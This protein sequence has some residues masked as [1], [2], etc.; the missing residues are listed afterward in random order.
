MD[1]KTFIPGILGAL[2]RKSFKEENGRKVLTAEEKT[3]LQNYGFSDRFL[4]DL[5]QYLNKAAEPAAAEPDSKQM[6][7]VTALLGQTTAQL[8]AATAELE[9][10]RASSKTSAEAL[11]SKEAAIADLQSKVKTLSDMAEEDPGAAAGRPAPVAGTCNLRDEN[12][13][14]GRQG[15]MFALADRPYNMRAKAALL[16]REGYSMYVAAQAPTD[17]TRLRDDLG[18]FYRIPWKDRLQSLLAELPTVESIFPLESGFQ[19]MATLVNVWLGEFSQSDNTE[20]SNFDDVTKGA[21]DFGSE[22]LRMF[23]VMFAV[24][25]TNLSELERLW[26]GSLNREGSNPIKWSFVEFLLAE[27]SKKLHNE[28]EMRRINGVRKNPKTNE[29][30]RAMDA[31]D[32]YF[33]FIRKK[34]DGSKDTTPDGGTTGSVVYQIK[35]FDLPEIT[36]ANIGEVLYKGTSE[37]PAWARDSG[38]LK[39]YLPSQ[40]VPW[41]NKYNEAHYGKNMDYKG[42][43]DYVKEFPNVGL[44]SVPNAEGHQRVVWTFEGNIKCYEDLPGEMLNFSMEQQDWTLKV[45]STWKE[46]VWAE[47]VGKKFTSKADMDGSNQMIW[48]T[49]KDRPENYFVEG[50]KDANPTVEQ[51]SSVRTVVNSSK[52]SITDING[53]QVGQVV[54]LQCGAAGEHGVEIK[55]EDKFSLISEAWEPAKGDVIKLMKRA[56]GKFIEVAR[57]SEAAQ[58]LQFAANATAP[59]V[60]GGTVFVVN[61]NTGTTALTNLADAV[62]GTVYTIYGAGSTNA[63]TIANSGNFVLTAAMTLSAG[64]FIKLVKA[65]DG[66]LYEV[67]RG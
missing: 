22:T 67:A 44:V 12:Q 26:I 39:C 62:E 27:T 61:E 38:K 31:A 41:Y 8:T 2:G 18:A 20:G 48:A 54:S 36:P 56:D 59:S 42:G 10:L 45:W 14:G 28:Q 49:A 16:A 29:A 64:K 9:R 30:G 19:D 33:E 60:E 25:F 21:Y 6:A 34:I 52:F 1:F 13:L 55:K 66:K 57:V 40:L 47:A 58:A 15:E 5:E 35:P 37:I 53:A 7:V 51:H 11:A 17:F 50:D 4:T 65:S 23:R 32:G 43:L 24:K 46:S 63:T 3:K